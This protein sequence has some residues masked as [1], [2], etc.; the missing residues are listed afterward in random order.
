M[1]GTQQQADLTAGR[2]ARIATSTHGSAP[3][4]GTTEPDIML[5]PVAPGGLPT[6]GFLIGLKA[7]SSGSATAGAGGFTVT[8]Y[9]RDP[10]TKRY[11]SFLSQSISYGELWGTADIDAAELYFTFG[12]VSVAGNIDVMIAEQ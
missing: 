1:A 12:N 3:T 2:T 7:P 5:S 10:V 11:F 6:T 9:C 8:V 4:D